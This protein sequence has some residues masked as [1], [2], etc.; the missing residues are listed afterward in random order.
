MSSR[1]G[2]TSHGTDEMIKIMNCLPVSQLQCFNVLTHIIFYNCAF[3]ESF[4]IC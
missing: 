2:N 3:K 1:Y 4:S